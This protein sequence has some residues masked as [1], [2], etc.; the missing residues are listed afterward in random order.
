MKRNNEKDIQ[1]HEQTDKENYALWH[2][3]K[4]YLEL[5]SEMLRETEICLT[6]SSAKTESENIGPRKQSFC[7]SRPLFPVIA[8][9]NQLGNCVIYNRQTHQTSYLINYDH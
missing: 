8:S 6:L 7:N 5:I 1:M 4:D 3:Y 2:T 9:G